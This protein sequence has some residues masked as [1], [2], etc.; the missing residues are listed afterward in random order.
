MGQSG[1]F[2]VYPAA[3]G[4][5]KGIQVTM[6][7]V[8]EVDSAGNAVGTSGNTKHSLNT[9]ASQQFTVHPTEM[10]EI[11]GKDNTSVSAAKVAFDASIN[12]GIGKIQ[13]DTFV[14]TS[15][16]KVGPPG[17]TWAVKKG[18]LKWN[19]IISKW[20]FCG[21]TGNA[22]KKGQTD[23]IGRFIELDIT[24]KGLK[25]AS[26]KNN[27]TVDLGGTN[28]EL[29]DQVRVDGGNWTKM[30]EKYPKI[31]IRGSQTIITFRF[32]KFSEN[33]F[34]DPLIGTSTMVDAS[35]SGGE[36][37]G[38]AGG[39]GG[40]K[41]TYKTSVKAVMG[42]SDAQKVVDSP[43]GKEIFANALTQTITDATV[44]D[45]QLSRFGCSARRLSKVRRLSTTGV[46]AD[47]TYTSASS[48]ALD[49]TSFKTSVNQGLTGASLPT[50]SDVQATAPAVQGTTSSAMRAQVV[51]FSMTLLSFG[52][53]W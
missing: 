46:Q 16:G 10:V 9:F 44:S 42:C 17:E 1:K 43:Q 28:L 22:C 12:S 35:G 5:E 49:A 2:T 36:G 15:G 8:R 13:V 29:S 25:D 6:D 38:G 27:K 37:G 11:K 53:F 3:K 30:T 45:T 34:Y 41:K 31:T 19:I 40:V 18:D 51:S 24:V 4:E 20:K 39:G 26:T 23:E 47:F 7:A 33:V 21:T 48:A 52:I 32:P 14:M 50:T